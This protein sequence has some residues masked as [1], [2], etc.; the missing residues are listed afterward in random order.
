MKINS[1]HSNVEERT[2]REGPTTIHV[3][4]NL[5]IAPSV[6]EHGFYDI[7]RQEITQLAKR[8]LCLFKKDGVLIPLSNSKVESNCL[9][10]LGPTYSV[11]INLEIRPTIV[12]HSFYYNMSAYE[13]AGL[14]EQAIGLFQAREKGGAK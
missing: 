10:Y 14:V 12:E 4:I 7:S 3:E 6:D 9:H 5:E 11:E 2:P 8:A 13:A 1:A